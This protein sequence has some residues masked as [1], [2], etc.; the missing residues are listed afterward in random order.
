MSE[1]KRWYIGA[2]GW[3]GWAVDAWYGLIAPLLCQFIFIMA[4]KNGW[5]RT[6]LKALEN[7]R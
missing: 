1:E 4:W 5:F 2:P 6:L 3:R 7:Y